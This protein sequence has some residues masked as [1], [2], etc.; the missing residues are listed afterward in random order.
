[1]I[2]LSINQTLSRTVITSGLTWIVVFGLFLFGGAALN[3]FAF[4]LTIGV[5]VGTYSSI[6]IASPILLLFRPTRPGLAA[7]DPRAK[8]GRQTAKRPRSAAVESCGPPP[9]APFP[10]SSRRNRRV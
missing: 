5:V 4:V 7:P 2:N 3:A 10:G 9:A 8:A 1:M 6:F